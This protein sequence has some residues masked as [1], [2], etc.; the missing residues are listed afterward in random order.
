M[1]ENLL[2]SKKKLKKDTMPQLFVVVVVVFVLVLAVQF[3]EKW[4]G[5]VDGA[6]HWVI[7]VSS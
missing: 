4:G 2:L 7:D 6:L 3:K 1:G 5:V